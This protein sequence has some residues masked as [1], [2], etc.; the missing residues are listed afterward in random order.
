MFGHQLSC[1][2]K[3]AGEA[4]RP[5]HCALSSAQLL[6]TGCRRNKYVGRG[7][8]V[9][10][11]LKKQEIRLKHFFGSV[12]FNLLHASGGSFPA[13]CNNKSDTVIYLSIY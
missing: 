10:V 13:V 4:R 3:A 12:I 6:A 1:A 5:Q 9:E 11:P 2:G 7:A 8:P